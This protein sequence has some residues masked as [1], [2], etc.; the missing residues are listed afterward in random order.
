MNEDGKILKWS[1]FKTF[2]HFQN[3]AIFIH[4]K[5]TIHKKPVAFL[6]KQRACKK[7]NARSTHNCEITLERGPR[8]PL[9]ATFGKEVY[10]HP[11]NSPE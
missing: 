3:F 4:K 1:H 10:I 5:H 2:D 6:T 9:E 7:L 11:K 8:Y